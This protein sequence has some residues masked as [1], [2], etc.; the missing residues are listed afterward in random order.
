[1]KLE[2]AFS[3]NDFGIVTKRIVDRD[4]KE[5]IKEIYSGH[6]RMSSAVF[7]GRVD[8]Y[9]KTKNGYVRSISLYRDIQIN[10][11]IS[12]DVFIMRVPKKTRVMSYGAH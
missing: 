7:P 11:N 4:G 12:D 6:K 2:I 3:I 10:K 9:A 1:L 5:I 8:V